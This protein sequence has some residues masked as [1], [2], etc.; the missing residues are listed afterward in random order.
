[1]DELIPSPA[2]VRCRVALDIALQVHGLLALG[3]VAETEAG[4]TEAVR[5][6]RD[7]DLMTR[8]RQVVPAQQMAEAS[9]EDGLDIKALEAKVP[10]VHPMHVMI[11]ALRV[12]EAARAVAPADEDAGGGTRADDAAGT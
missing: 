6:A 9:R 10:A 7:R 5:R 1:M 11:T 8:M 4:L 3:G 12:Q 2:H